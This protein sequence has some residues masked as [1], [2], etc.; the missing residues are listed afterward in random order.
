VEDTVTVSRGHDE[1]VALGTG[2]SPSPRMFVVPPR[3]PGILNL[4]LAV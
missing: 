3:A 1:R 4:L 2:T